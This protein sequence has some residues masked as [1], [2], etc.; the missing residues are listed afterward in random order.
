M[1]IIFISH[2]I[3]VISKYVKTIACLNKN[4]HY[5]HDK[6][7]TKEMLDKTYTCP[8]ELIAH[9]LPHRVYGPHK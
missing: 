9:G 8:V 4:L 7:I 1:A 2:D 5:H 6:E 3:S